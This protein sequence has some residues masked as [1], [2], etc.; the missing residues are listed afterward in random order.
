ME[1]QELITRGRF[2]F[3]GAPERLRVFQLVNGRYNAKHIA[4][5]TRRRLSNTLRDLQKLRDLEFIAPRRDL[6]GNAIRKDDSVVYE[7]VPLA[8]QV[9]LSYFKR[10]SPKAG[11]GSVVNTRTGADRKA[12]K[13]IPLVTPSEMEILDVARSGEDQL[14][15]FKAAGTESRKISR[16]IAAFV[17]TR[18]GGILYYGVDDDGTISGT[19][20]S[21]Q[22]FD[23]QIQNSI[24][25]MIKP[26]PLITIKSVRPMGT[27]ILLIL[28]APWDRKT[29]HYFEDRVHIR[30][31]TNVFVATPE[32]IK[33]LHRGVYIT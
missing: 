17:H 25:N 4:K 6:K 19:N 5:I 23:Q 2:T 7:K 24:R 16:E 27:E 15:E 20:V 30:K 14:N 33:C 31:G 10:V 9:P 11:R 13:P 32:E 29:V 12:K 3:A 22:V 26:A 1:L 21:R 18:Q 8:R 28:V